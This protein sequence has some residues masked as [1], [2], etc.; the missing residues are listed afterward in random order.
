[1]A[2]AFFEALGLALVPADVY[3][4]R[5]ASRVLLQYATLARGD[6]TV[7]ERLAQDLLF[8][9]AQAVPGMRDEA[10]TLRAV[11]AAWGIADERA[12]DY[13]TEQFGRF[14]PVVLAQARKRIESAKEMWSALSA[15]DVA[16]LR[17]VADTFGQL[18]ESLQKLHPP[19]MPMAQALTNAVDA[20]LRSG[21]PPPTELAMEVAT[22]VL[23]LEAAFEDLDPRDR[24]LTARTVQLAGRIERA[25]ESGQSEPLEPWMEELY[26]RV[27]DRQTMGTVVD[28]LRSHLSE[29]EKSLDQFFRRPTEMGLLRTVPTQLMQMR[30][31]FSVLGLDQAADTVQR[32]RDNVEELMGR[33][34]DVDETSAF[35]SL[36][37]NLGALGF[38]IDML[39]YQP[40][41]A[42]RLFV[43]DADAGELKPLMGRQGETPATADKVAAAPAP[44]VETVLTAEQVDQQ[45]AAKLA[46]LASPQKKAASPIE[47]FSRATESWT[48][49]ITGPAPLE[50]LPE[51]FVT[52]LEEDDLQNIFLD[53]ARE[54]VQNGLVAVEEL[55]HDPAD[56]GELTILRRAFHTLKGSSRMVGL[57][58]IGDAAWSLEQLLNTWLADQRTATPE[59][60][61]RLRHGPARLWRLGRGHRL[62]RT[63]F[64][65]GRTF[66][67]PGGIAAHRRAAERQGGAGGDQLP[68][69][70]WPRRRARSPPKL[71]PHRPCRLRHLLHPL[72]WC[73][74]CQRCRSCPRWTT[75]PTWT[76][77]RPSYEPNLQ[78][79]LPIDLKPQSGTPASCANAARGHRQLPFDRLPLDRFPGV[80]RTRTHSRRPRAPMRT[81]RTSW[82]R[83]ST[84]CRPPMRRWKRAS[85]PLR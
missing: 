38:L 19:S 16:R 17:Q 74:S 82:A 81:S 69:R 65:A 47:E 54:V 68:N 43:F 30:G 40:A 33:S 62:G 34:A 3:V 12:V 61:E 24:Q 36:G 1:M 25:R 76:S 2:G 75:C 72:R 26:R 58:D 18:A 63:A 21:K 10:R 4:K 7:S 13:T 59:L 35:D 32:M 37:N 41:L 77:P 66:P 8:F 73:P 49:K 79:E 64:L 55:K 44:A 5:A 53:E 15:G 23:Y 80:R 67:R 85:S 27:S 70:C 45:I 51:T 39:G 83:T 31:V 28:E 60:L 52:E 71:R 20:S 57:T 9:C 22:S 84:S 6:N 48:A 14:D 56:V 50:A 46:A 11:R 78:A 29:L 42:K